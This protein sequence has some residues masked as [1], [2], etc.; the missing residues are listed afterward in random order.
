MGKNRPFIYLLILTILA[1][2]L[3]LILKGA[4]VRHLLVLSIIFSILAL[5]LDIIMG[6]MGQFSFGHQAFFGLG[7]YTTGILTVKAGLPVWFSFI[8]G[9]ASAGIFGLF[10]GLISLNRARG[11]LLGI[12][13]LGLG[14]IVWLVAMKWSYFTGGNQGLPDIPFITLRVPFLGKISLNSEFS[15][16]YFALILLIFSIYVIYVFVNSRFGK[17]VIAVR[18]NEELAS[19]IGVNPFKCYVGAFTFACA[20]A[21]LAGVIYS[22]YMTIISPSTLSIHYMFWM[23][24]MVIVGGMRTFAGPIFGAVIF[25]FLP[26]WLT[27]AEEFRMVIVGV[28]VLLCIL[29]MRRGVVPY[30]LEVWSNI[31]E[32]VRLKKKIS[33]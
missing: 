1:V 19:S 24:V 30:L 4:Y 31:N 28:V 5:S 3:P 20:L 32:S 27:A 22:H 33:Q 7:A 8:A 23:L 15:Y 17:A 25:V 14:K 10:I 9:V 16:Y 11:F 26:E 21:G 29:F 2:F 12:I 6:Y 18:E 13:T